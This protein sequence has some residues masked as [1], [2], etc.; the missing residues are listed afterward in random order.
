MGTKK[1]SRKSERRENKKFEKEV[2]KGNYE[3]TQSSTCSIKGQFVYQTPPP[4]EPLFGLPPV[5]C[6]NNSQKQLVKSIDR[7]SVV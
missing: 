5:K 3:I 1:S 4:S 2:L 7:K 6:M